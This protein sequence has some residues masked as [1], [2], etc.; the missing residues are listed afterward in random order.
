VDPK[1]WIEKFNERRGLT[2]GSKHRPLAQVL[3]ERA[4]A[5]RDERADDEAKALEKVEARARAA[6]EKALLRADKA[7]RKSA[8]TKDSSK[9]K[10]YEGVSDCSMPDCD[11][12]DC[13]GCD[14]GSFTTSMVLLPALAAGLLMSPLATPRAR[15]TRAVR[16]YRAEVSPRVAPRCNLTPTCSTFGRDALEA[17]GALTSARL[18]R[19][20]L[21]QCRV[22]GARQRSVRRGSQ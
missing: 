13:D 22:E 17:H 5:K 10:W 6:S 1:A 9:E 18:I 14:C 21:R 16:F 19:A 11:L 15:M 2:R 7:A 4:D 8:R 20:R 3:D 12:P